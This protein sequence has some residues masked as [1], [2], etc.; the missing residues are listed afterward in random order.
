[1]T[2]QVKPL[3]KCTNC[4]NRDRLSKRG[5]CLDCQLRLGRRKRTEKEQAGKQ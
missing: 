1:M 4:G 3:G 5:Q 2:V